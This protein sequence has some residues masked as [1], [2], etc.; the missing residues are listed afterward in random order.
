MLADQFSA[1]EWPVLLTPVPL[2]A[3]A[4]AAPVELLTTVTVALK[5]PVPFGANTMLIVADC[6]AAKVAPLMPLVTLYAVEPAMLTPEIVTLEFPV[7]VKVTGSVVLSPIVSFPKLSWEFEETRLVVELEVVPLSGTVTRVV[8]LTFFSVNVPLKVPDV[9][10]L[11]PTAKYVVPPAASEKGSVNE[12]TLNIELLIAALVTVKLDALTFLN[13]SVCV[14]LV[15]TGT[16]PNA[17]D[18]GVEASSDDDGVPDVEFDVDVDVLPLKGIAIKTVPL[19]FFT[20]RVPVKLP[21]VVG[22]N[23]TAK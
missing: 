9:V 19:T 18:E 20:V 16:L 1:T 3:I 14:T 6:P 15:P 13:A 7:L 8:P 22:L 10:G 23:P 17:T 4:G 11:N 12:L 2:T 5:A 21:A